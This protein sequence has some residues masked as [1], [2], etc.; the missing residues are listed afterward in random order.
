MEKKIARAVGLGIV[1]LGA[2]GLLHGL[3][4]IRPHKA[5]TWMT[6]WGAHQAWFVRGGLVAAGL[7]LMVLTPGDDRH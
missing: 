2:A 6:R 5:V 3:D 4:A 7:A 1:L